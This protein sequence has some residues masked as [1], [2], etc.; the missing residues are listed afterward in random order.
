MID[1]VSIIVCCYN[2]AQRLSE[3]VA[4]IFELATP[5]GC[6][7]EVIIVNNNSTD[8][9]KEEAL[10]LVSVHNKN[11]FSSRVVDEPVQG[12]ASAR[13]RG[14]AESRYSVILF[15]DD[16]NHLKS[17][18][19]VIAAEIL[20]KEP[21]IGIIGG[22]ALP[23]FSISSRPWLTQMYRALAIGPQAA[24]EGYVGW[25]YGAGMIIRKSVFKELERRK[26]HLLLSDRVGTKQTSGGDA[27]LCQLTNYVG[28]KIYYSPLLRLDHAISEKRLTKKSFVKANYRNIY[29]IVYLFILNKLI[30]GGQQPF[31]KIRLAMIKQSVAQSLY[32]LPR[33]VMGRHQFYSFIMLYQ[34][35]QLFLWMI[36]NKERFYSTCE[37]V[38]KNLG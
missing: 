11:K 19:L 9:T 12:L 36:V 7:V 25:V 26:I 16:D 10:R 34:N 22:V 3:T 6:Q 17:D 18:Y 27:E 15:C 28:F 24:E 33:C 13:N 8:N 29:P 4:H 14:L 38:K 31:N 1:G 2:S 5:P 23:K 20:S 21:N 32:F 35:I 37:L 30:T